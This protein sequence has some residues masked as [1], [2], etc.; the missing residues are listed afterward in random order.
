MNFDIPC[1]FQY[2]ES[3]SAEVFKKL[4][5]RRA[6][7]YALEVLQTKKLKHTKMDN[8]TYRDLEMQDYFSSDQIDNN[9]KR[10]VFKL[11]TRMERFGENFR[12]GRD[13]VMCP[14]CELHLDSQDLSLQ[15]PEVRNEFNCT[16][17]IREIY[18]EGMRKEIVQTISKVIEFRRNKIENG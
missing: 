4:V 9:Q 13:H 12:G 15:C 2:I 17:D 1:S 11:R 8:V 18:G 7:E 14:I 10:T 6:K 16:G 3:K 5:K